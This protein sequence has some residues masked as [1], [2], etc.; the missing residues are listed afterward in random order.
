MAFNFAATFGNLGGNAQA[1]PQQQT[2][3]QQQGGDHWES[4]GASQGIPEGL[5]SAL[6]G[7]ESGG[8]TGA[9]SSK[10]AIGG[11][12]VM[13]GTLRDMGY[14]P[15][16]V[17]NNPAL[18]AEAGAKYLRQMYDR[19]GDWGLA[20]Q[21]YHDGPGNTDA[22]LQG[23][24]TP[25]PEGR[26]YVDS[27]FDQ[28]T[29]G[30]NPIDRALGAATDSSAPQ[31]ATSARAGGTGSTNK[32]AS[33]F[34]ELTPRAPQEQQPA[35]QETQP[36]APEQPQATM[37]TQPQPQDA[38]TQQSAAQTQPD[39]SG[40]YYSA[41]QLQESGAPT[42]LAQ[43][44]QQAGKGLV[45]AA[46]DVL[47]VP[48]YAAN[49]V[50]SAGAWLGKQAG[51]G[52]GT[53]DPIPEGRIGMGLDDPSDPY[54]Q[55]GA[56]LVAG[57]A[58]LPG[59][60]ATAAPRI[61]G[62]AREMAELAG[63]ASPEVASI[64]QR[65]GGVLENRIA[66]PAARAVPGA[67]AASEGDQS[68]ALIGIAAG[69]VG[70]AAVN[71]VG[72]AA[73]RAAP[74]IR[75]LIRPA[76]DA[77]GAGAG[78]GT[79][80]A[81]ATQQ[82]AIDAVRQDATAA[83]RGSAP[84]TTVTDAATGETASAPNAAINLARRGDIDPEVV[85]AADELGVTDDLTPG[86]FMRDKSTRDV[87]G[88]LRSETGSLLGEKQS[89]QYQALTSRADKVLEDL[90]G[91]V[92]D[93][94]FDQAFRA[95]TSRLIDDIGTAETAAYNKSLRTIPDHTPV[96]PQKTVDYLNQKASNR[97]GA[98][99]L[100]PIERN[101]LER[102]N[103]TSDQRG[104][105]TFALLDDVRK[106]VGAAINKRQGPYKDANVA[107]LN[108]MYSRLTE[109]QG[110]V[111]AQFGVKDAWDA[112]KDLTRQRVA[113]QAKQQAVLG[114]ELD[115]SASSKIYQ[116][117][118]ALG[119]KGADPKG[120]QALMRSTPS[121]MRPQVATNALAMAFRMSGTTG[122]RLNIPGFAK[123]YTEARNSGKLGMLMQHLPADQRAVVDNLAKIA[124]AA[125]KE[126]ESFAATG[127][128]NNFS[129]RFN[130]SNDFLDK[131][132]NTRIG[133]M[134]TQSAAAAVSP[135]FGNVA[136]EAARG[137]VA[138]RAAASQVA[139]RFL[140]GEDM[141][142]AIRAVARMVADDGSSGPSRTIINATDRRLANSEAA[143][144]FIATLA[145]ADQ[146]QIARA[147]FIA[148]LAGTPAAAAASEGEQTDERPPLITGPDGEQRIQIYGQQ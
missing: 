50:Q 123:W 93:L 44:V 119:T 27:R 79:G 124:N 122:E 109:D 74:V 139:D 134:L 95:E 105:P 94:T 115:N 73:R 59:G 116:A 110:D 65:L 12:Q 132:F 113:L 2:A 89:R 48:I 118:K 104:A 86:L 5:M 53:Y 31:R 148:W 24:Y 129:R 83:A 64:L 23:K 67:L 43:D 145:E 131:V 33:Q 60:A 108:A 55:F 138:N 32:F 142:Q 16:E 111:A 92:E 128:I 100:D 39:T 90:G 6:V 126:G 49:A 7:K 101:V 63:T 25:G 18:Q 35:A 28:W 54:A 21:A 97:G 66:A 61:Q 9:T 19:Y 71:A 75:D 140:A 127:K 29:G 69:P 76:E 8:D 30:I 117:V 87:I 80:G 47:N 40:D 38:T 10:G 78:A 46:E 11:T 88:N 81:D 26:Q 34:G 136:V 107:R 137:A 56:K 17:R 91:P 102:L 52:D 121:A 85:R 70:E 143:Q 144:D 98:A 41:E 72:A 82:A 114:K 106:D 1:Q 84:R 4:A 57:L 130:N 42:T 51:I 103:P 77:T 3:P 36:A 133:A 99:N 112:A 62:I 96:D 120:F 45:R 125:R 141:T 135:G 146:R 15:A 68:D 147:G 22:M 20:L 37:G 14:D 13:P 58:P